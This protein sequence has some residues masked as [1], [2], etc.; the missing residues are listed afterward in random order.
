MK[1]LFNEK[2]HDF[3]IRLNQVNNVSDNENLIAEF[4]LKFLFLLYQDY[5][6]TENSSIEPELL[7]L[8]NSKDNAKLIECFD[9]SINS[10]VNNQRLI[11]LLPQKILN[12]QYFQSLRKKILDI[13]S[14]SVEA[15]FSIRRIHKSDTEFY[16]IIIIDK[17]FQSKVIYMNDCAYKYS[18]NEVFKGYKSKNIGYIIESK[19]VLNRLDANYYNPENQ[20]ARELIQAKDSKKLGNIADIFTGLNIKAIV[21]RAKKEYGQLEKYFFYTIKGGDHLVIKPQY[22]YERKVHFGNN[23]KYYCPREIINLNS[24]YK[25]YLLQKGDILVSSTG[26]HEWA[27][28][29]GEENYAIANQNVIIVRPK[30]PDT[31]KLFTLFFNSKTGIEYF[32]LQLNFLAKCE[33]YGKK[34]VSADFSLKDIYVPDPEISK[35]KRIWSSS[36]NFPVSSIFRDS[37]WNVKENYHFE[38]FCYDLAL[39]NNDVFEAVVEVKN[40]SS[41]NLQ[42]NIKLLESLRLK[43]IQLKQRRLFVYIDYSLFEFNEEIFE[44]Q[45][46]IPQPPLLQYSYEDTLEKNF[47]TVKTSLVTIKNLIDKPNINIPEKFISEMKLVQQEFYEIINKIILKMKNAKTNLCEK[48]SED[49]RGQQYSDAYLKQ[50]R[51]IN[52]DFTNCYYS[53]EM[54]KLISIFGNVAWNKLDEKSKKCL[55]TGRII[56]N[57][58]IEMSEDFDYSSVCSAVSK[59]LEIELQNRFFNAFKKFMKKKYGNDLSVYPTVFINEYENHKKSIK[60]KICLGTYAHLFC[61]FTEVNKYYPDEKTM[62]IQDYCEKNRISEQQYENNKNKLLEYCREQIFL[63][64]TDEEIKKILIEYAYGIEKVREKYRNPAAHTEILPQQTAKN[65]LDFVINVERLLIKMLNSFSF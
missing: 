7:Y 10:L 8:K 48:F 24:D 30:N 44:E 55:T 16:S 36:E 5:C 39:F 42:N 59:A 45:S 41:N 20:K 9:N 63:N 27:V 43:K 12:S 3:I 1:D 22:I 34:I 60:N 47:S 6:M 51:L 58:L 38:D 4:V 64:K 29:N 40:Y 18:A 21:K 49:E 50:I 28:Y 37:G 15:V 56:Y 31:E 2:Y 61:Y 14:I 65:C 46:D 11:A 19:Y 54:E 17:K 26:K 53:F 13:E 33:V 23:Q 52:P 62:T 25:K 35:M 57:K 32:D